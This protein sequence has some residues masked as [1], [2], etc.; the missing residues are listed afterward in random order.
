M[1]LVSSIWPTL[2]IKDGKVTLGWPYWGCQLTSPT[3]G[4]TVVAGQYNQYCT[5]PINSSL[6]TTHTNM[7]VNLDHQAA[8]TL[9]D[10]L[11]WIHYLLFHRDYALGQLWAGLSVGCQNRPPPPKGTEQNKR[12]DSIIRDF[13][14]YVLT[15]STSHLR[16]WPCI[17]VKQDL[18]G[19]EPC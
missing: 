5:R 19:V 15:Q 12:T 16:A 11:H 18:F 7:L 9:T 2:L 8:H 6:C 4:C 14:S 1:T 3:S 10:S 17:G 13:T